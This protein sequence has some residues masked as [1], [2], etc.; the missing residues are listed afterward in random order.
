MTV[1][2]AA[3]QH[4]L[5]D[6]NR[7]SAYKCFEAY[8]DLG[9]VKAKYFKAYYIQQ[10]LVRLDID[11]TDK[12]KLVAKLYKEASDSG[13][14]FPEAQLRYGDCLFKG[15]GVQRDLKESA[16]YF[17]KAAENGKAVGMFNAATLYLSDKAGIKEE[18]LGEKYMRLAAYKQHKQAIDY[19]KKNGLPL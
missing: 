6:G 12:N 7:E 4:K 13:D 18:A 11:Q 16:L 9:D 5:R 15:V 14:E 8:A 17:T 10:K 1:D 3:K 2:E 19:C